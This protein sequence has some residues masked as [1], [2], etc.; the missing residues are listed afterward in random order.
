MERT[1]IFKPQLRLIVQASIPIDGMAI[2]EAEYNNLRIFLLAISHDITLNGQ[3]I[4][5]LE[6]C[7]KD[8]KEKKPY[9]SPA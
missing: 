4:K 1:V 9:E 6:P 3:I 8:R 7:C 2:A 5:V